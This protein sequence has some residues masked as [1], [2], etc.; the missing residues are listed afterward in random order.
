MT[1]FAL[2]KRFQLG[3]YP[4]LIAFFLFSNR[5]LSTYVQSRCDNH[6]INSQYSQYSLRLIT[7]SFQLGLRPSD[8]DTIHTGR[9]FNRHK[10][11]TMAALIED[12]SILASKRVVHVG[13]LADNGTVSLVRAAMIPFG[14]IKSC[15]I[16]STVT[17]CF[18]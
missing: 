12:P 8:S 14:N 5:I 2:G 4:N 17:R 9:R 3:Q 18:F 15:D 10:T 6:I 13:G 7:Q 11:T 1:W 16:V